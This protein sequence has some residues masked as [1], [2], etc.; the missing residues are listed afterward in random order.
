MT[1]TDPRTES[2]PSFLAPV[3][4]LLNDPRDVAIVW[5]TLQC[6][7]LAAVGVSLF[8]VRVP[9]LYAAPA[10]WLVLFVGLIDR[11]TL[12][13]H[14]TS[15]RPLFK[16]QY[17][18]LNHVIPWL[19]GPFFGQPPGPYFAH[20]L[21]MHHREENLEA[22]LSST[23]RFRRDRF[24]HWL[25]YFFRFLFVGLVELEIYFYRR[26]HW[27]LFRRVLVGEGGFWLA[28]ALLCLWRPIPTLVVFVVPLLVMRTLMMM[29]N[30]AQH[31]FV[32]AATPENPYHASIT[33]INTRY[34]RRCFN[35]GYHV[36]HHVKPG[37]HWTQHPVEFE[38]ALAEYARHD[39]LVFEGIDFFEVWLSLMLRRWSHLADHVVAL[40]GAPRRTREQVI[41]M[42]QTRVQPIVRPLA[43]SDSGTAAEA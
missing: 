37:C 34:N 12:M 20:H 30:W 23:M 21:G 24:D 31:S 38:R 5:L 10:Y 14:C 7:A 43:V 26:K 41:E 15:H 17:R 39:S 33:C 40:D 32:V 25:R 6:L 18:A 19:V 35:D 16:K 22:D 36:L 4:R 27:K 11:F 28:A 13:L 1:F 29:G 3:A 9:W 2:A 42:L 8:F